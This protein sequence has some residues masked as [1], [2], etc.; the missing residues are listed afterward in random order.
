M[1]VEH[2]V[3]RPL[4]PL[5][6][7]ETAKLGTPYPRQSLF[8]HHLSHRYCIHH[9]RT[10]H[11][12]SSRYRSITLLS[13]FN[14]VLLINMDCACNQSGYG[15]LIIFTGVPVYLVFIYWK[16]KPPCIRRALCK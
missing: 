5:S 14:K 3:G 1:A 2:W 11:R 10:L 6:A 12:F 16:N 15:A 9:S 13:S 7:L 8:P 4:H